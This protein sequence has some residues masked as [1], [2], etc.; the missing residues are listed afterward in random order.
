V[1]GAAEALAKHLAAEAAATVAIARHAAPSPP[2]PAANGTPAGS[3]L[4]LGFGSPSGGVKGS[5]PVR[6]YMDATVVPVLRE[7]L[8]AL[9]SARPEDPLQFLAEFLLAQRAAREQG[10]PL[11]LPP[12]ARGPG[13][14]A[15][16]A[17]TVGPVA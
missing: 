17:A 13:E 12:A 6:A 10:A 1:P 4:D 2:G 3:L 7:G 11:L 5:L 9:N 8:K 15:A 16:R 14:G